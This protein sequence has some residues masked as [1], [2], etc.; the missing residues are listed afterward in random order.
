MA[1][2][3]LD[4]D[5]IASAVV[6]LINQDV[7]ALA[8]TDDEYILIKR[9]ADNAI[10]R[11]ENDNGILWLELWGNLT[12]AADGT[13]TITSGTSTYAAPTNF[14]FPGGWVRLTSGGQEIRYPVIKPG[15]AQRAGASSGAK[16]AYFT[17]NP[18]TGYT[19]NISPTPDST[20]NGWTIDYDYYALASDL[21]T[22]GDSPEMLDPY[23]IVYYISSELV[24]E[25]DPTRWK[26][27][28][29]DA[30]EKLRQM[31][32][33]NMQEA[34]Y[35]SWENDDAHFIGTGMVLGG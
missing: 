2:T 19:L 20:I 16:M 12:G 8:S 30:E 31:E 9:L 1:T 22:G 21:S 32:V 18:G 35:Q 10:N 7:D 11:W 24:R 25:E 5:G 33:N 13:K 3:N 15:E 23:F 29:D 26:S 14:R 28:R 34:P 6:A 17:G 4:L 27:L